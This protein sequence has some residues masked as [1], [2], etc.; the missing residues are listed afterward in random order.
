MSRARVTRD[1]GDVA[2]L[3]GCRRAA[4]SL[5]IRSAESSAASAS[6]SPARSVE[7]DQRI[8]A[9]HQHHLAQQ[10]VAAHL[11]DGHAEEPEHVRRQVEARGPG[12]RDVADRG[13]DPAEDA[14]RLLQDRPVEDL[15]LGPELAVERRS[16]D[17]RPGGRC[18]RRWCVVRRSGRTARPPRR[19]APLHP[20]NRL[21]HIVAMTAAQRDDVSKVPDVAD[22]QFGI[23]DF[24]GE[25]MVLL[26]AGSTVMYQ[27]AMKGVG[28][29][30][31]EHS[32][33]A[34]PSGR[35]AADDAHLHLRD[36]LGHR[37]RAEGGRPDGQQDAR[38][39]A[40][41]GSLL[42]VRSRPAAVGRRD[43]PPRSR[44]MP[45][46]PRARFNCVRKRGVRVCS[47]YVAA[48]CRG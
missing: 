45:P 39:G 3:A 23:A 15:A 19:A 24:V 48:P 42:R 41:A 4:R 11:V 34:A 22:A 27:L 6:A 14:G 18:R 21:C 46:M 1:G 5:R 26:G 25:Q 40:L 35:P 30:V 8:L 29:G 17:A 37:G 2:L 31:A 9:I 12:R 44:T 10:L 7:T 13:L 36:D 33:H 20:C 32:D 47:R 38:S 43:R 28:L 16:V